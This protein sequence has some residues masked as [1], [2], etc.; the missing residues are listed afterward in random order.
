MAV[1]V[2]EQSEMV[3]SIEQNIDK[4]TDYMKEGTQQLKKANKMQKRSR[5]VIQTITDLVFLYIY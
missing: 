3:A 5:K 4:A 1:L 2:A